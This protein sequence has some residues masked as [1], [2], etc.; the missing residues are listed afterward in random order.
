[1]HLHIGKTVFLL[2]S[3]MYVTGECLN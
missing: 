1:M 3:Q 2:L